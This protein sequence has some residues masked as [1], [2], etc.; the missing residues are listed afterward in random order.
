[1]PRSHPGVLAVYLFGSRA[2]GK[3]LKRSD[4]DLGVANGKEGA[5]LL[6]V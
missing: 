1:M 5:V 4:F 3:P 6:P 2:Y